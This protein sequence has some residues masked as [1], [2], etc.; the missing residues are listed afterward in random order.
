[1][2]TQQD[3][4]GPWEVD[5]CLLQINLSPTVW[6]LKVPV[7]KVPVL[8]PSA[9]ADRELLSNPCRRGATSDPSPEAIQGFRDGRWCVCKVD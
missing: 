6:V 4:A 1:M 3:P 9:K 8:K 2:G 7:L 5:S